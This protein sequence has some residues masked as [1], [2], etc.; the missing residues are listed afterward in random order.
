[1]IVFVWG[2]MREGQGAEFRRWLR[3]TLQ[4]F[5]S[6]QPVNSTHTM[7]LSPGQMWPG[8]AHKGSREAGLLCSWHLCLN[9]FAPASLSP[10]TL[11]ICHTHTQMFGEGRHPNI[12]RL[13]ET[14]L[15]PFLSQKAFNFWST[16][17]WY[18]KDGLYY[19]GGMVSRVSEYVT[20]FCCCT[21]KC[22]EFCFCVCV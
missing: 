2:H 5:S 8:V 10:L 16:R 4:D 11:V 14:R 12:D 18:F 7:F 19:Q 15:A 6:N 21:R 9:P 17:L 3:Q 22:D 1:M 13:F 20:H